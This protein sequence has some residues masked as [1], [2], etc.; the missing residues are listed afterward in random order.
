[1]E[2]KYIA[3]LI[4][5]VCIAFIGGCTYALTESD[6]RFMMNACLEKGAIYEWRGKDCVRV[7]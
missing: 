7:N 4:A 3:T 5:L 6:T 1:M 2:E